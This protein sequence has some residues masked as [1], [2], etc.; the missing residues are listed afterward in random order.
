MNGLAPT[1]LQRTATDG[2]RKTEEVFSPG[3]KA[4]KKTQAVP[5]NKQD[6][7][8]KTEPDH[9]LDMLA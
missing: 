6:L 8:V 1:P 3:K 9:R 4:P 2:G 5:A 7:E